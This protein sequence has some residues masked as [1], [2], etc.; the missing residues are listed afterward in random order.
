[1]TKV[2]SDLKHNTS[3]HSAQQ[4]NQNGNAGSH[5]Y[6][7]QVP[8]IIFHIGLKANQLA[9]YLAIKR[10]AGELGTSTKATKTLAD[11][12]G[13]SE[14]ILKKVKKQLA[15]VN[16]ILGCPLIKYQ[17]RK[18]EKGNFDTDTIQVVDIWDISMEMI[19]KRMKKPKEDGYENVPTLGTKTC[20][21]EEPTKEKPNSLSEKREILE[22]Q[23]CEARCKPQEK[24]NKIN[25][26]PQVPPAPL[27]DEQLA[28]AKKLGTIAEEQG[29]MSCSKCVGLV[30]LF[31]FKA[32]KK[33][34]EDY[35]EMSAR[36]KNR[37]DCPFAVIKANLKEQHEHNL[38]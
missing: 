6:F 36:K 12:A 29:V 33:E 1:M 26:N 23:P 22:D 28:K 34:L 32:V 27:S 37:I 11:E 7:T 9:V 21:K 25:T 35:H 3:C 18:L 19:V 4:E 2:K 17:R 14:A 30:R 38:T 16:P 5:K 15:E 24:R 20:P 10:T 8:N 31:G 13:V